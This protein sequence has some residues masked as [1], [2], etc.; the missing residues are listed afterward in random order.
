VLDTPTNWNPLVLAL[1]AGIPSVFAA[2][3]AGIGMLVSKAN[4]KK[5][6][7]IHVLVNSNLTEVKVKLV[8]AEDE[9]RQLRILVLQLA[10]TPRSVP[11]E[12]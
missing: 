12:P 9:I 7:E 2:I 11:K 6:D 5:A 10:G 4:G 1:A 8:S 3:L